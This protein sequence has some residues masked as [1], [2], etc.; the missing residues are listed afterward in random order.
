MRYRQL[1]ATLIIIQPEN[2]DIT[3]WNYHIR[4]FCTF[5][6]CTLFIPKTAGAS[7]PISAVVTKVTFF[8]FTSHGLLSFFHNFTNGAVRNVSG[9][10]QAD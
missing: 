7:L 1:P 9:C 10:F 8:S 2:S 3:I 4:L 6:I 5:K